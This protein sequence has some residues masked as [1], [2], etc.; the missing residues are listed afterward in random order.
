MVPH[1]ITAGSAYKVLQILCIHH[2]GT[3]VF[4]AQLTSQ[5]WGTAPKFGRPKITRH[6]ESVSLMRGWTA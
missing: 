4:S 1:L 3:Q 5:T 2:M 6:S